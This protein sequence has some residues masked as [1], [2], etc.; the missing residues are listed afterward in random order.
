MGNEG[1]KG[2]DLCCMLCFGG[3]LRNEGTRPSQDMYKSICRERGKRREVRQTPTWPSYS[4]QGA[5][6]ISV[7]LRNDLDGQECSRYPVPRRPA[8]YSGIT[9]RSSCHSP[10]SKT[11][12][13]IYHSRK[14]STLTCVA[15][16]PRTDSLAEVAFM[17]ARLSTVNSLDFYPTENAAKRHTVNSS[18]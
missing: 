1:F 17:K 9:Y 18:E 2:G 11:A 12:H 5:C 7:Q 15:D 14:S 16:L 4:R 3:K 13:A 8:V 10:E 6:S